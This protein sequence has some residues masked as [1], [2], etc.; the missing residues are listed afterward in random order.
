[1]TIANLWEPFGLRGTP[2]FQDELRPL[3]PEHPVD[4]FVGRRDE[5]SLVARR[6]ASDTATRTVV[7]GDAGVGKTSFINK[8]KSEVT[9]AGVATYEHPIRIQSG[10][11]AGSLIADALRLLLR[12]RLAAK[13]RSDPE[14]F[15]SR[16]T[17]L[18]EGEELVGGSL[19]AFGVGGGMS[20]GFVAPQVGLDSLY[21][22]LGEAL[23][24]IRKDAPGGVL[25]HVNNL[26]NLTEDD[27]AEASALLRDL[28][29]HLMLPGAHWVFGGATGVDEVF[30]RFA[31][32]DGIFPAAVTLA[33][34]S[35]AEM[36][37]LLRR[38][39]K[40]LSISGRRTVAPVEVS[41]AARLYGLYQ[42][43]LR[44]FL[45]LLADAAERGLG[46]GGV[47]PMTAEEVVR[48]TAGEYAQN[49]RARLG[50]SDFGH[51]GEITATLEEPP[52]F[53]VTDAA[54]ILNITQA[55]AS[56]LVERLL[57]A[58]VIRRTRS[59]GRNVFYAPVGAVLVAAARM[60]P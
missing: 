30:R 8:I 9:R 18:L 40:H 44:S 32:V 20:R 57:K 53:R 10:S 6:I 37:D 13:W 25:I 52:E 17:R 21:E 16:T 12:I 56:Q 59:A 42:G 7:Q 11:T 43:D 47:R 22:H 15:W 38:R 34:I 29:D 54:R 41:V 48:Q 39:Y 36:E 5:V 4:L 1:M 50:E 46:L 19:S 28:R 49:L 58:G 35:P 23:R 51:L 27:A 24:L 31:Q 14:G 55:S 45:R 60:P 26:E 3:D 2:F 33:P